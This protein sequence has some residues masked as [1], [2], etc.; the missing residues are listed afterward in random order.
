MADEKFGGSSHIASISDNLSA[1]LH[2]EQCGPARHPPRFPPVGRGRGAHFELQTL[3]F[4]PRAARAALVL[5][6][7]LLSVCV[8]AHLTA[9]RL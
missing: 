2:G 4:F 1:F 3:F 5:G 7:G 8:S 9:G 6:A